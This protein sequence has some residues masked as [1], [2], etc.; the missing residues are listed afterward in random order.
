MTVSSRLSAVLLG[1]LVT[2]VVVG[3]G[4]SGGSSSGGSQGP[5]EVAGGPG[6]P[7][8]SGNAV[9]DQN[10]AKCH[11][12]GAAPGG[13]PKGKRGG[14]P[15]LSK[16]GADPAHTPEWIAEYVK[17]PKAQKPDAKMPAFGEKLSPEQ[18]KDV[19]EFLANKK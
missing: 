5:P 9:Y 17:N 7:G 4:G 18:I 3:C 2:A 6:G 16:V 12:L 19:S 10:C 1:L 11:P 14:A 8:G 13:G 15:D